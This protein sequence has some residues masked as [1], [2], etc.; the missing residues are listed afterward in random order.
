LATQVRRTSDQN[1]L[2]TLAL[3]STT[4]TLKSKL[5][6]QHNYREAKLLCSHNSQTQIID[7][8]SIKIEKIHAHRM[9]MSSNKEIESPGIMVMD[10]GLASLEIMKKFLKNRPLFVIT[11]KTHYSHVTLEDGFCLLGKKNP[12]KC[13]LR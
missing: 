2:P 7:N 1:L 13:L 3:D 8:I 12:V 11:I 6:H 4:I 10:R 9:F 5:F